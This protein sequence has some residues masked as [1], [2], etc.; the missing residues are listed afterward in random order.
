MFPQVNK[1]LIVLS[2]AKHQM[3][4][5][6]SFI[7]FKDHFYNWTKRKILLTLTPPRKI[8]LLHLRV[9]QSLHVIPKQVS[10]DIDCPHTLLPPF[11]GE[12][13][14]WARTSW[15]TTMNPKGKLLGSHMVG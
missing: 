4:R 14:E 13:L 10:Q 1:E 6:C 15:A 12:H 5:D 2:N 11:R 7:N 9:G 8:V 3:S